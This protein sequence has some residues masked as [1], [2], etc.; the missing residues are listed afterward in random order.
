MFRFQTWQHCWKIDFLSRTQLGELIMT[1]ADLGRNRHVLHWPWDLWSIFN[2]CKGSKLI[3]M[4]RHLHYQCIYNPLPK[5]E[6]NNYKESRL[7]NVV[8]LR[9]LKMIYNIENLPISRFEK[10]WSISHR[11]L[12]RLQYFVL[13][14]LIWPLTHQTLP[15][16]TDLNEL[17]T[18]SF[19]TVFIIHA[20]IEII[21]SGTMN[22]HAW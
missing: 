1:E 11:F 2:L 9:K 8:L 4:V 17:G 22:N 20:Y 14:Q 19:T 13:H 7:N 12:N 3:W 6:R 16:C 10:T 15:P 21:D 5:N 18:C